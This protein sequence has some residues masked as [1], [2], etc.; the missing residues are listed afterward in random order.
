MI[1]LEI[2]LTHSMNAPAFADAL[3]AEPEKAL[4]EYDLPADMIAK[5]KDMSR[6][7]FNALET[8]DRQSMSSLIGTRK[9]PNKRIGGIQ[10]EN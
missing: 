10:Y 2:I 4:A 7:D 8:E 5:F 3:L 9:G 1:T 6:T